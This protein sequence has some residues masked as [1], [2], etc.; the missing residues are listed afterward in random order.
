MSCF[1]IVKID[2][3]RYWRVSKLVFPSH[4][5][6]VAFGV[7]IFTCISTHKD[8]KKREF[9]RAFVGYGRAIGISMRG[10]SWAENRTHSREPAKLCPC[11]LVVRA[12]SLPPTLADVLRQVKFRCCLRARVCVSQPLQG[13]LLGPDEQPPVSQKL[14]RPTSYLSRGERLK[15]R[16]HKRQSWCL[17]SCFQRGRRCCKKKR[18]CIVLLYTQND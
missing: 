4:L 18:V 15:L 7:V 13:L 5:C 14:G 17:I 3:C 11:V 10:V 6:Q 1:L 9:S 8:G 16:S 12:M 2:R